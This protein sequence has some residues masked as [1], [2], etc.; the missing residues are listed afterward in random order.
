MILM[1]FDIRKSFFDVHYQRLYLQVYDQN[2]TVF[3]HF[4]P[5]VDRFGPQ[6]T[7]MHIKNQSKPSRNKVSLRFD[8]I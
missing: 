7:F 2:L 8:E 5:V 6:V 4:R 3:D 1:K